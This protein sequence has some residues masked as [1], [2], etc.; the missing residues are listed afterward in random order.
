M[1]KKAIVGGQRKK[2]H[3]RPRH[4]CTPQSQPSYIYAHTFLSFLSHLTLRFRAFGVPES[5]LTL[6]FDQTL[7]DRLRARCTFSSCL[8]RY[9][10]LREG[11][12]SAQLSSWYIVIHVDRLWRSRTMA[13]CSIMANTKTTFKSDF[14]DTSEWFVHRHTSH[15]HLCVRVRL[16]E[17]AD[18]ISV[19]NSLPWNIT[20]LRT[21]FF[22]SSIVVVVVVMVHLTFCKFHTIETLEL[23]C[24]LG[25]ADSG[26]R[27]F[28]V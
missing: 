24:V 23:W 27:S 4:A 5:H 13:C 21:I 16:N 12:R 6:T 8:C 20:Q 10:R 22:S 18:Q 26:D 1:W 7:K 11:N 14:S 3:H 28:V 19:G 2:H 25:L 9:A 15:F 17:V